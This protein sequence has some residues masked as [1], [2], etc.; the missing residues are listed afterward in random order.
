MIKIKSESKTRRFTCL[1]FILIIV[2]MTP[3]AYSASAY[4]ESTFT[5]AGN[6]VAMESYNQH[7]KFFYLI[8]TS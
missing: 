8:E 6:V 3:P 1:K 5:A 4:Y 7:C 2:L